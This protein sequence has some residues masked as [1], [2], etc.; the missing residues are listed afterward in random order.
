MWYGKYWAERPMG[1]NDRQ[2]PIDKLSMV[3]F[4][5]KS[6]LSMSTW[7]AV[8]RGGATAAAATT[9]IAEQLNAAILQNKYRT[10]EYIYST[11]QTQNN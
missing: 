4:G 1:R 7:S 2:P 8:D 3:I 6:Y 11:N 9:S 5:A 10:I